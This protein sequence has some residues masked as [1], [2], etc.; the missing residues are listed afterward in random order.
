MPCNSKP[1]KLT[2]CESTGTGTDE[3][4]YNFQAVKCSWAPGISWGREVEIWKYETNVILHQ[5]GGAI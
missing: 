2:I 3:K 4:R 5:T 1:P